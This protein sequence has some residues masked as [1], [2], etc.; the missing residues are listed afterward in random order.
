LVRCFVSFEGM[1]NVANV[2]GGFAAVPTV[3][4]VLA[5]APPSKKAK[6]PSDLPPE[7]E[8][9]S[10]AEALSAITLVDELNPGT[11]KT[12]KDKKGVEVVEGVHPVAKYI[13]YKKEVT[14]CEPGVVPVQRMED[15]V[16]DIDS[17]SLERVRALCIHVGVKSVSSTPKWMCRHGIATK[18]LL[19][20]GFQSNPITTTVA[21]ENQ[22][23]NCLIRLAN[24]MLHPEIREQFFQINDK[25]D[26]SDHESGNTEKEVYAA[27]VELYNQSIC[28]PHLDEV[29]DPFAVD[30]DDE[31]N[32]H[33]LT[34]MP[35]FTNADPR[36]FIPLEDGKAAKAKITLLF[37]LRKAIIEAM[38]L[39]GNNESDP[40]LFVDAAKKRVKGGQSV[41]R[42]G[43]YYFYYRCEEYPGIDA[44]FSP[45]LDDWLKGNTQDPSSWATK[46]SSNNSNNNKGKKERNKADR[47]TA[48]TNAIGDLA[49]VFKD[50]CAEE[51]KINQTNILFKMMSSDLTS[52]ATK[53]RL[54]KQ[55][56]DSIAGPPTTVTV[57]N[58]SRR[59]SSSSSGRR[60]NSS[61]SVGRSFSGSAEVQK[62]QPARKRLQ[63]AQSK[64]RGGSGDAS[65]SSSSS[66]SS[67]DEE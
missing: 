54:K 57:M 19:M 2:N 29:I 41:H 48:V 56:I 59:S 40:Y 51:T 1:S 32:K 24:T 42:L 8:R 34:T 7:I 44:K 39:S 13:T 30:D 49:Q 47:T 21:K 33:Y 3:L 10:A 37:Q 14:H 58:S 50:V 18:V 25:K 11:R 23:L 17:L 45:V 63:E 22:D 20:R 16:L 65:I 64:A 38:G 35:E 26:R 15:F 62:V 31:E 43:I 53:E 6:R 5:G 52:P 36:N 46:K 27:L 66:S 28:D 67:S 12:T 4:Q 61:S 55:I 9:M 60:S